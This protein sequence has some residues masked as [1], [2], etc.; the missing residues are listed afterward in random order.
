[1]QLLIEILR[2]SEQ[3]SP[4][5]WLASEETSGEYLIPLGT[6]VNRAGSPRKLANER[7]LTRHEECASPN[8]HVDVHIHVHRLI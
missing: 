5:E 2:I 3:T 8:A 4:I 6:V 7:V 1:M